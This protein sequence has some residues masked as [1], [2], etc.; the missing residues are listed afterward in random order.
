MQHVDE[1]CQYQTMWKLAALAADAVKV[2]IEIALPEDH[3]STHGGFIAGLGATSSVRFTTATA[4][5]LDTYGDQ[6]VL[7]GE[8]FAR[9]L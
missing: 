8:G 9:K 4:D 3:L 5:W 6:T 2:K 1:F 7:A